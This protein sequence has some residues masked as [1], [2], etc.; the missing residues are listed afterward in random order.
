MQVNSC[1]NYFFGIAKVIIIVSFFPSIMYSCSFSSFF[2]NSERITISNNG[3]NV[4]CEVR[5]GT[6]LVASKI[7]V[8]QRFDNQDAQKCKSDISVSFNHTPVRFRCYPLSDDN[9]TK[10][11]DCFAMKKGNVFLIMPSVN[12][13]RGGLLKI[14]D[15]HSITGETP[16]TITIDI[17]DLRDWQKVVDENRTYYDFSPN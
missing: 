5:H 12:A 15:N 1:N 10:S 13:R 4:G 7:F 11:K 14:V 8:Y 3:M 9:V 6:S 2:L 17:P 16:D